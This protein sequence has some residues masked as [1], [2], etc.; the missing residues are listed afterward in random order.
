MP[1]G[2]AFVPELRGALEGARYALKTRQVD[3]LGRRAV[4]VYEYEADTAPV[5]MSEVWLPPPSVE[6][7]GR[8]LRV[9]DRGDARLVEHTH[10][11]AGDC[12]WHG[13]QLPPLDEPVHLPTWSGPDDPWAG[14]FEATVRLERN[15]TFDP[16]DWRHLDR[17]P[18]ARAGLRTDLELAP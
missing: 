13:T 9:H 16:L 7:L 15:S 18:Q 3:A 12:F 11:R 14:P 1:T 8:A 10:C 2:L 5:V 17:R 6:V 4:S